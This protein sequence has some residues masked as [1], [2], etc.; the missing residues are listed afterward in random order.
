MDDVVEA[1]LASA[2]HLLREFAERDGSAARVADA[3]ATDRSLSQRETVDFAK[4][5]L[6]YVPAVGMLM[7]LGCLCSETQLRVLHLGASHGVLCRF[8]QDLPGIRLALALDLSASALRHGRQW[9]LRAAVLADAVTLEACRSGWADVVLAES[10]YVPGYWRP[11]AIARSLAEVARVLRPGGSL[12]IQEWGF[13]AAR[14][15]AP[16]LAEVGLAEAL[17]MAASAPTQQGERSV[18]CFAFRKALAT[19][20]CVLNAGPEQKP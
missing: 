12:L 8:L 17:R 20:R 15:F 7:G 2:R 11:A 3:V 5:P 9:G 4:T 16:E 6:D 13:D 19:L 1:R 14:D 18:T 10:L